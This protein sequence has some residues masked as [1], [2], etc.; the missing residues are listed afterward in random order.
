[1]YC[2]KRK[3]LQKTIATCTLMH[4]CGLQHSLHFSE[5]SLHEIN[6]YIQKSKKGFVP[7]AENL[8]YAYDSVAREQVLASRRKEFKNEA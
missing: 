4:C 7:H 1:M 2:S 3:N 8:L 6:I 5:L